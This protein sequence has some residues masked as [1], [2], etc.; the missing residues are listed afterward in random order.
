MPDAAMTEYQD[1]P[2]RPSTDSEDVSMPD[3]FETQASA[4]APPS[5]PSTLRKSYLKEIEAQSSKG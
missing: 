3:V 2:E 1:A 5:V 4:G